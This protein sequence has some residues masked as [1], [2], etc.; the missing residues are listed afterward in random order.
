MQTDLSEIEFNDSEGVSV[1]IPYLQS[2]IKSDKARIW[3]AEFQGGSIRL[4]LRK[5]H[6]LMLYGA[7]GSIPIEFLLEAAKHDVTILI[8]S[9]RTRKP[10]VLTQ[11]HRAGKRD[12]LS[13]QIIYR[14]NERKRL[15]IAK[16]LVHARILQMSWQL[17]S[18]QEL[19]G[20]ALR[21]KSLIELRAH[22]A[23]VTKR[24]WQRFYEE[25]G[26]AG[27][28]RREDS[29]INQALNACGSF[30]VGKIMRW[31]VFHR[32][33]PTH[34]FLH[35]PVSYEALVYD[36]LEPV[37]HWV[38]CAV[39]EASKSDTSN[40]IAHSLAV[41]KKMLGEWV[42]VPSLQVEAKRKQV[43][44]GHVLALRSYLLNETRKLNL[45]I[46]STER[47]SGRPVKVAYQIPG[48]VKR[49]R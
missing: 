6:T 13:A 49:Y 10:M 45:P 26:C 41:L 30:L 1:W 22:E 47:A 24:Y 29:D 43:L 39:M 40:L 7:S 25:A 20:Q 15:V 32:L 33:S 18:A 21:K 42:E 38:E 11:H 3:Q 8:H 28:T 17:G 23:V 14:A 35:E 48:A 36:L 34:G 9:S 2:L 16:A 5:I 37:R 31:V 44:H 46:D 12:A 27:M 19:A 4:D